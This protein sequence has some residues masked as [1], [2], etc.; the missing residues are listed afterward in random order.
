[1]GV[2]SSAETEDR[3]EGVTTVIQ[4]SFMAFRRTAHRSL[5]V[6]PVFIWLGSRDQLELLLLY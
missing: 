3:G 2:V 4:E 5:D 6:R 1:M